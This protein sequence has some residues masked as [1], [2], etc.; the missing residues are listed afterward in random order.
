MP[1]IEAPH[2]LVPGQVDF[3]RSTSSESGTV[4][5]I[6]NDPNRSGFLALVRYESPG[7]GGSW[8]GHRH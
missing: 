8:G 4:E 1:L 3:A 6:E 5:R 2:A 7:Q